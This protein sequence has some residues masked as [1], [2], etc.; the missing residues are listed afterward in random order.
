[1]IDILAI[2]IVALALGS[3]GVLAEVRRV[4]QPQEW[5]HVVGRITA[6]QVADGSFDGPAYSV[7]LEYQYT[8]DGELYRG[9]SSLSGPD[10]SSW[11]QAE[12]LSHVYRVGRPL[13]V[14]YSPE[15]PWH[16]QVDD[17]RHRRF[18]P[19]LL[20]VSLVVMLL[21]SVSLVGLALDA[22]AR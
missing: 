2:S 6:S 4:R 7:R 14:A 19:G 8:V 18:R 17:E 9:A 10:T 1:M 20:L 13:S 21:G 15:R 12:K 5:H 22:L 16:S 11:Q 3:V